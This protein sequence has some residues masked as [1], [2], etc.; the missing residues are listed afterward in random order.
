MSMTDEDFETMRERYALPLQQSKER[1]AELEPEVARLS[2]EL[3]EARR[4]LELQR[5]DRAKMIAR[6]SAELTKQAYDT[7]RAEERAEKR[8][9]KAALEK[10]QKAHDR[11]QRKYDTVKTNNTRFKKLLEER[12]T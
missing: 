12:E 10:L 6:E 9:L 7:A 4:L 8:A 1:V 2:E 11:L 3:A 5:Q